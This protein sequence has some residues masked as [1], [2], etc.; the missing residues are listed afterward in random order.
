MRQR[1]TEQRSSDRWRR[2]EEGFEVGWSLGGERGLSCHYGTNGT[3]D[4]CRWCRGDARTE[5]KQ[6]G[7]YREKDRKSATYTYSIKSFERK[8]I[9]NCALM[10]K[11]TKINEY[12]K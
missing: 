5:I 12:V 6:C 4:W 10:V 11:F 9:C 7:P 1:D 3:T 2:A 8:I